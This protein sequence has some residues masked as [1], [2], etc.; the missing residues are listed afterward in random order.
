LAF[1]LRGGK[2]SGG[3]VLAGRR[4][5]KDGRLRLDKTFRLGKENIIMSALTH[6]NPVKE[7]AEWNPFRELDEIHKRLSGFFGGNSLSKRANGQEE[8]T[9][10]EW[11][12]LVDITED[13]KEYVIK[14]ELPE[15]KKNE[16]KVRVEDSV[17]YL[18]GTRQFEKEDAIIASNAPMARP[19]AASHCRMTRIRKRSTRNSR[20]AS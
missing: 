2:L 13:D 18:S 10:A 3:Q 8:I 11:A 4:W 15:V 14:A 20:T 17:L 7:V 9:V 1:F 19:R 12:P 16:V 6:W 5:R